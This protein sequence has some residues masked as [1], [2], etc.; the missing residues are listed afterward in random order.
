MWDVHRLT[1][2]K[3]D[4]GGKSCEKGEEQGSSP[5]AKWCPPAK[6]HASQGDKTAPIGHEA[7]E[8]AD[9]LEGEEGTRQP[10]QTTT[11]DHI[12]IA[13]LI[14]INTHRIGSTRVVADGP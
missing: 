13:H 10:R 7:L 6:D 14:D 4:L 1:E 3:R 11:K 5:G 8:R 2:H 12:D 9:C